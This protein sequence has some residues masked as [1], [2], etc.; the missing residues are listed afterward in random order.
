MFERFTD[1]ARRV[2]VLAGEE[3]R[4]LGH[5]FVG[6]EHLLLGIVTERQGVAVRVLEAL[7][8]SL[9][10]VRERVE[11]MVGRGEHEEAGNIPFTPRAKKALEL[12]LR[13]SLQLGQDYVGTEHILLGLVREGEGVAAQ[14]LLPMGADIARTRQEVIRVLRMLQP[15]ESRVARALR[16]GRPPQP[17]EVLTRLESIEAKLDAIQAK[18]GITPAEPG[19]PG[20][21]SE[22][23]ELG[24]PDEPESGVA[25]GA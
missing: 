11:Q 8:I 2:V 12:A 6:T 19:S 18:L 1:R 5:N 14:V 25:D 15:E 9:D 16:T 24:E 10:D 20:Q 3:A 23:G 17:D 4:R 22:P 13:E 7:G 21:P